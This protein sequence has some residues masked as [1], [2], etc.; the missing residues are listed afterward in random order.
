MLPSHL[1]TNRTSN[2]QYNSRNAPP[3]L[4]LTGVICESRTLELNHG[5]LVFTI[6]RPRNLKYKPPLICVAGGPL[7]PCNYLNPLV[8]LITDR[9]VVLYD[10]V[11]CGQSKRN[12]PPDANSFVCEIVRELFAIIKNVECDEFHLFGHSFGGIVVY[13]YAKEQ[14]M[15]DTVKKCRSCILAST[16]VCIADCEAY[17]E[18]LLQDLQLTMNDAESS[19]VQEAFAAT[20]EC[21]V[22]PLPLPLHE[23]FRSAS[24]S[25][26]SAAGMTAVRDYLAENI[27]AL[28]NGLPPALILRGEYD[29]I[30]SQVCAE[31][32]SM[33]GESQQ[34]TLAGCSHYGMVEQEALYGSVI[35][36][37]LQQNDPSDKPLFPTAKK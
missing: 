16:P 36:S 25:S 21:R 29:F 14:A 2:A 37:F 20:Y 31:W 34:M 17:C 8:H 19:Q 33:F 10:A 32:A 4:G 11:G 23:T 1:Q 7:L 28:M 24:R 13:E 9:S 30:T 15:Y 27:P 5:Q 6:Y 18:H 22:Q 35:C 3:P 26:S 12:K